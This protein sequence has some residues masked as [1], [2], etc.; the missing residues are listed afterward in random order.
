MTI[1][2]VTEVSI[3]V[4]RKTRTSDGAGGYTTTEAEITG[5]PF[6]GRLVRPTS[7]PALVQSAPGDMVVT[8]IVLV[9]AAGS[10]IHVNDICTV[11]TTTY[12]VQSTR[13]YTRSVQ[14]DVKAVE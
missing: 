5:S 10:D 14:A 2:K 4:K 6:T 12:T 3:T 13:S 8:P 9:F 1:P 7:N 11:G